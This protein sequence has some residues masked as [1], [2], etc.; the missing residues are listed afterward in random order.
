MAL[1]HTVTMPIVALR[2]YS[3]GNPDPAEILLDGEV[4][5]ALPR[6]SFDWVGLVN[7]DAAEMA[8]VQ[9][10]FGLHPLDFDGEHD[11]VY[12][13]FDK[14]G[15]RHMEYVN[16]R[17]SFDDLPLDRIVADF[18][19]EY[20]GWLASAGLQSALLDDNFEADV[21]REVGRSAG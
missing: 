11:S 2:H 20:P 1:C 21:A 19:R 4:R 8:L 14:A 5:R 9:R 7:P 17:G 13:A 12:H 10:Q 6:H 16:E 15:H 3:G 18:R